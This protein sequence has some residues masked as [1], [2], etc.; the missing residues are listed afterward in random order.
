[1][2]W[3]Q[4]FIG[5][6]LQLQRKEDYGDKLKR[7]KHNAAMDK[8]Q[9]LEKK[10]ENPSPSLEKLLDHED[11]RVR[12]QAASVCITMGL[13]PEKTV[14]TLRDVIVNEK[15]TTLKMSAAM[16]LKQCMED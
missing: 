16:L 7:R 3:E 6:C 10:M 14:Q 11:S 12:N 1:M 9:K 4:E 13:L 5:L 15:D 8:L 2:D